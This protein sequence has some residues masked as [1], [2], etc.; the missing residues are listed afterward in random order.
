MKRQPASII[1]PE[2]AGPGQHLASRPSDQLSHGRHLRYA[3]DRALSQ[4]RRDPVPMANIIW[5]LV[6]VV[7]Y[8]HDVGLGEAITVLMRGNEGARRANPNRRPP[9]RGSI[10]AFPDPY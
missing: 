8:V 9:Q 4:P 6:V 5:A 2:G 10:D 7:K 3:L 1:G